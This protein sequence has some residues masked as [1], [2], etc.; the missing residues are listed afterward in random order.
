VQRQLIDLLGHCVVANSTVT[1]RLLPSSAKNKFLSNA[2]AM[3]PWTLLP[4]CNVPLSYPRIAG[5]HDP[6]LLEVAMGYHIDLLDHGGWTI[7]RMLWI[8]HSD[9]KDGVNFG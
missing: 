8:D 2:P 4:L 6:W 3:K 5:I 1:P 9:C 7:G